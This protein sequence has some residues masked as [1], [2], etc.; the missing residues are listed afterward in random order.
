[1]YEAVFVFCVNRKQH[2]QY[3]QKG[4]DI[5]MLIKK[6]ILICLM[7]FVCSSV[8]NAQ[9]SQSENP[10]E[11]RVKEFARLVD[12]GNR[13]ELVKYA[14]ENFAPDFLNVPMN[15][16]LGFLSSVH[17]STRGLEFHSF[18][19]SKPT[20]ATA[21]FKSKLTGQW[22]ALVARVESQAPY[23]IAGLGMRAPKPPASAQPAKKL[24]NE[25]IAR[26]LE[27]LVKK[28]A[29]ADVFS[30]TVLLAKDGVPVFKGAYGTAN[31]DFNVPNRIDTKFNLGSMN[32]MFTAVSIAQLVER[33]KLSFDDPLSKF[34]PDFP[35]KA[36]AEK[37]K[38][39]H[40]LS[41]TAGLGGYFSRQWNEASRAS[42]RTVDDMMKRAAADEKLL[43]EPGA[44]W[45]YSNTGMLV[46]GKVIEIASGQNYYDYVRE[47]IAKPAGM[48]N[49]DCYEL[50]KVNPNLAIGYDKEYTDK[51]ITFTNNIFAHVMRGGPQGGGYSTVE[52]LLKFDIALRSNKLVGAE[53]VKLL[54]SAKS[55]LKSPN[56]GYGFQIDNERQ[57]A[58]HS[59]GFIGIN[60][61]LDMFL[62]TG[63]TAIMMSNYSR[64]AQPIEQKMRE[65]VLSSLEAQASNR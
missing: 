62:G 50:D 4:V 25:Q 44:R 30:G 63:W 27:T 47:N 16:H 13:A 19:D 59:G 64:G 33:G 43:F 48:V 56:Y 24:T 65:L 54:L 40:L 8:V 41:H 31:K 61:N 10:A 38:I 21:L 37:I 9:A 53:Y 14:K 39:K 28:L 17:D 22:V 15:Q 11:R 5:N 46:L 60:A 29:D 35:D 3:T 20:E 1:L 57:I 7:C 51:G 42:Y 52:D 26:E 6:L 45:Q 55:E 12:T 2:S 23:R 34:L 18:Q 32:K 36:S 58:G 49:S